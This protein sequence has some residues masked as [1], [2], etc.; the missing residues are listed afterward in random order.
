ME[1]RHISKSSVNINNETE[2]NGRGEIEDGGRK[3]QTL[4]NGYYC[5]PESLCIVKS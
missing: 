4:K 1:L 3:E 5:L 2:E